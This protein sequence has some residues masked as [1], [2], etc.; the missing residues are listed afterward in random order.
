M[1]HHGSNKKKD[2]N[3]AYKSL[4]AKED[5]ELDSEE[6]KIEVSKEANSFNDIVGELLEQYKEY[7]ENFIR[8]ILYQLSMNKENARIYLE[9]PLDD[10]LKGIINLTFII[11]IRL[12]IF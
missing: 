5:I 9:N 4:V 2:S 6:K 1:K 11:T 3:L 10:D 12:I 8:T 7:N